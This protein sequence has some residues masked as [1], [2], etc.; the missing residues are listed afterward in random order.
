QRAVE[1]AEVHDA[2]LLE[3][4]AVSAREAGIPVG[5]LLELVAEAG[6]PAGG[7][8]GGVGDLANIVSCGVVATD[9]EGERVVEAERCRPH[10]SRGRIGRAY[11]RQ[12]LGRRSAGCLLQDRGERS[13]RVL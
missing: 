3:G 9:H 7:D 2:N 4:E 5:A 11:A 8:A 12:H 6:T 1:K 10:E 13:A